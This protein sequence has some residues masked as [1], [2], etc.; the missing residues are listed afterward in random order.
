[1]LYKGKKMYFYN[2]MGY[3]IFVLKAENVALF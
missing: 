1:M 3:F 2:T